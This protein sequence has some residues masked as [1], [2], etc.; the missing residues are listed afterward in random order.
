MSLKPVPGRMPGPYAP[1]AYIP[2]ATHGWVHANSWYASVPFNSAPPPAPAG[3]NPQMWA[4]GQWQPNPYFRPPQ[5]MTQPPNS[6]QM[7]APHPGW[8]AAAGGQNNNPYK[9]IPNPGDASYWAT[10]LSDNPLMLEN[11]HIKDDT[12]AEERHRKDSSNGVPHTPWVWV[13]KEL[14][15]DTSKSAE[16]T[17]ASGSRVGQGGQAQQHQQRDPPPSAYRREGHDHSRSNSSSTNA[18]V[19]PATA[20][21]SSSQSRHYQYDAS[22]ASASTHNNSTPSSAPPGVSTYSAYYQQQQQQRQQHQH[23]PQQQQQQFQQRQPQYQQ[24]QPQP[25]YQQDAHRPTDRYPVSPQAQ[26]DHNQHQRRR[27]RDVSPRPTHDSP[28]SYTARD[29]R[30]APTVSSSASAA[31]AAA[32]ASR[33]PEYEP[34]RSPGSTARDRE[35]ARDE[36]FSS[37]RELLPT[38]SP[39]IVRTPDHYHSSAR[40]AGSDLERTPTRHPTTPTPGR[41]YPPGSVPTRSNSL[42]LGRQSSQGNITSANSSLG[43]IAFTEEPDSVLSPLIVPGEA[44]RESA[45]SRTSRNPSPSRDGGYRHTSR[46]PSPSRGRDYR[47]SS[48]NP[49]P[50]RDDDSDR[51]LQKVRIRLDYSPDEYNHPVYRKTPHSRARTLSPDRE[52]ERERERERDERNEYARYRQT[53]ATPQ[54][55]TRTP[56]AHTPPLGHYMRPSPESRS[57]GQPISRSQTYPVMSPPPPVTPQRSI[58]PQRYSPSRGPSQTYPSPTYQQSGASMYMRTSPNPPAPAISGATSPLRH[59]PLPRPPQTHP[60][61]DNLLRGAS[62]SASA[63]AA[64]LAAQQHQ[65]SPRRT[66]RYGYWN[67]RGDHLH[68][69]PHGNRFVVYAPRHLANP[70]ELRHYPSPTEGWRDHL[71]HIIKYDST[72]KELDESLPRHGEPPTRPYQQFVTYVEV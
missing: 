54:P 15:S 31:A 68:I 46:N 61:A 39:N 21:E 3:M 44:P 51:P 29:H 27:S 32:A 6:Y 41:V 72:V 18:Y 37:R 26:P 8:G 30:G 42:N 57:S 49:S 2:T 14:S 62:S 69:D 53:D 56:P 17:G 35:Q 66:V 25:Q 70:E 9:R 71:G 12:P 33:Q 47:Y 55:S 20:L 24:Q 45:S 38:F 1:N 36:A 10:K 59:N 48:R 13:P 34:R 60:Y 64:A 50:T 67:R 65:N 43:L 40:L 58:S 7:W 28:Q 63:A 4:N 52:R 22:R 11:M 16:N 19:P 23:Q 5:G